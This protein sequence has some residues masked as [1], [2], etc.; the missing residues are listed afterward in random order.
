[1][2]PWGCIQAHTWGAGPRPGGG[3]IPACSETEPLP[4]Q[5]ATA[6][7]GTHPTGM[8]S[9]KKNSNDKIIMQ[10]FTYISGIK[11]T[12]KDCLRFNTKVHLHWANCFL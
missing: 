3:G 2:W 4:Q 11:R 6:A 8:H 1:M 7:G 5:M 10:G 12:K 9:C